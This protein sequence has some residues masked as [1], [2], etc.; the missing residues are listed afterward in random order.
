MSEQF[1]VVVLGAG[2]TVGPAL[3]RDLAESDEVRSL[4]LLD[5]DGA[6]AAAV[7]RVHGMGK[8]CA[9]QV[10]GGGQELR[11]AIAGRDV[12][13]N[14]ASYR[15]N[16]DAMRACLDARCQYVDLGGLYWMTGHQLELDREFREAG[17]LALLGMGSSPG[18]TN[19]MAARAVELL[20]EPPRS[21][22]IV[23]AKRDLGAEDDGPLTVPYALRTLLD[24]LTMSPIAIRDGKPVELEPLA[25]GG[26]VSLPRPFGRAS[27]IYSI[28]SELRTLPVTL[29]CGEVS[30]RLSL[31]QTLLERLRHVHAADAKTLPPS[32][33]TI[34]VD[35]VVAA[36]ETREVALT[37]FTGP[38]EEW[39]IGGGVV[40]AA[41][42][43]AAAVRL[44][45]RG[46]IANTGALP[47]ELCISP[48]DLFPELEQ[49]SCTFTIDTPEVAHA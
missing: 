37:A 32:P 21:I 29:G 22:D 5:H 33:D 6:R 17:L 30:L 4:L 19:L 47:P 1:D 12:L 10:D 11:A 38:V 35:R 20:A 16:L 26:S 15:V 31:P 7:A 9:R 46:R 13:V 23:E 3:V 8:A 18:K 24:E 36:G 39:G 43:A 42:P 27:T 49:R 2:G 14:C 48:D 25:D 44:L 34:A 28:G 41:A 45:A 40:S